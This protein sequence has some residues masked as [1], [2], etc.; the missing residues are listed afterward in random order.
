M[1][2]LEKFLFLSFKLV[3]ECFFYHQTVKGYLKLMVTTGILLGGKKSSVMKQSL[4]VMEF[5]KKL[6]SIYE[7][8]DKL[9]QQTEK[10]YNKITVVDLL[11]LCPA[12]ST[13]S[14]SKHLFNFKIQETNS[15]LIFR[16]SV[17]CFL[18]FFVRSKQDSKML[19]QN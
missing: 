10:I 19:S 15:T 8:K 13:F 16:Y 12:V 4:E 9:R 5:E 18:Y 7:N 1:K 14:R 17:C 6:A 11:K 3:S 2:T